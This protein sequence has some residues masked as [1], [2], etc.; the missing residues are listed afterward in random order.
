[1]S[2]NFESA[3]RASH[4]ALLIASPIRIEF[5]IRDW[6]LCARELIAVENFDLDQAD[7][8]QK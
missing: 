7:R 2:D 4:G 3:V 1:M 5:I 8:G 6:L